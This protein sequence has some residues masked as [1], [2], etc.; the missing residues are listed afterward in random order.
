MLSQV[1]T[2]TQAQEAIEQ[3]DRNLVETR[4]TTVEMHKR[5]H[6]LFWANAEANNT[7][8]GTNCG[9]LFRIG[10]QNLANLLAILAIEHD[11]VI[12][13]TDI[14]FLRLFKP[15]VTA[16]ECGANFVPTDWIDY[17]MPPRAYTINQDGSVAITPV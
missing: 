15:D 10:Q 14:E 9:K 8:A 17:F 13:E 11:K 3:L 5:S 2:K 16:G 7:V 6:Q 12:T 4:N 1:Q